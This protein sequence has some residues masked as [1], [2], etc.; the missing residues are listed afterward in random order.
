MSSI[1]F[2]VGLAFMYYC[3][4]FF[5]GKQ[6][7][8]KLHITTAVLGF[9]FE[10]RAVYLMNERY[11]MLQPEIPAW[12]LVTHIG[13]SL[14]FLL[15]ALSL[16]VSGILLYFRRDCG[17]RRD[18]HLNC[19]WFFFIMWFFATASGLLILY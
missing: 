19:V 13:L 18:T 12:L 6:K 3:V 7:A 9:A 10:A 14:G 17:I 8:I 5:F 11:T 1:L 4:C 15:A 2:Y 16:I